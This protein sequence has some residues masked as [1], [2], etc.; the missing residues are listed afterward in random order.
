MTTQEYA[1]QQASYHA[2]EHLV[3]SSLG[4]PVWVEDTHTEE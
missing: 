3:V 4:A 2:Y 1:F